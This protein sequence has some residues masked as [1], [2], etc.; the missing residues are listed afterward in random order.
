MYVDILTEIES[1]TCLPTHIM[2]G[3]N[4]NYTTLKQTLEMLTA[5]GLIEEQQMDGSERSK[6]IYTI[7]GKGNNV[8]NYFNLMKELLELETVEIAV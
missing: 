1:G 7:T 4:M 3:A 5:Q 6:R 2:Y 8:L